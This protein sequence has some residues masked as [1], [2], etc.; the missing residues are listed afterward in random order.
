MFTHKELQRRQKRRRLK[1]FVLEE[2]ERPVLVSTDVCNTNAIILPVECKP[3]A[4]SENGK[5]AHA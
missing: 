5:H 4:D 3:A 1:A 2:E